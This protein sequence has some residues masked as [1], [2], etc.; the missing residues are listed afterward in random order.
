MKGEFDEEDGSDD[1]WSC[2]QCEAF[3]YYFKGSGKPRG[4]L[5]RATMQNHYNLN[6]T[7]KIAALGGDE[8]EVRRAAGRPLTALAQ[9]GGDGISDLGG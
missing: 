1:T 3:G 6:Y 4:A 5:P 9:V 2:R 8:M 7:L